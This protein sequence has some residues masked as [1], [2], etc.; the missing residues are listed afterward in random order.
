M[1][2]KDM[3]ATLERGHGLFWDFLAADAEISLGSLSTDWGLQ[4]ATT[5]FKKIF[6]L[7]SAFQTICGFTLT[8]SQFKS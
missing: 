1:K 2:R 7:H 6:G 3:Y 5:V 8:F 4:C